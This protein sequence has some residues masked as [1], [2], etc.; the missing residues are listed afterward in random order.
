MKSRLTHRIV[1]RVVN[2]DPKSGIFTW[3]VR[4]CNKFRVGHIVGGRDARGYISIKIGGLRDYAH[5]LAWLYM[6]G[7]YPTHQIDHIN[8]CRFDNKWV[9]LREANN[10]LNAENRR[11]AAITNKTGLLGVVKRSRG[12]SSAV[13]TNGHK[14][15][16]GIFDTAELA[17]RA[18][19]KVKRKLHKGCT[20]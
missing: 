3:K 5:R 18:Y 8:G 10:T 15:H 13:E 12:F 14:T 6:T 11:K 7:K 20:I 4:V 16:C 19:I 1:K 2:Y 9:N 17:H